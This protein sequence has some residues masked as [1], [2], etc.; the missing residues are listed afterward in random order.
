[1]DSDVTELI[2]D[3]IERNRISTTE[4]ADCLG[5]TGLIPKVYPVNQGLFKVGKVHWIYAYNE[6]NWEVHEQCRDAQEKEIILVESFNCKDRA[7]MQ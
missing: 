1:M 5:K 4:V 2:I 6:S 3:K 7:N